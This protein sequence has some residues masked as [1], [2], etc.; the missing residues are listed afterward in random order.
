MTG[1]HAHAHRVPVLTVE[2]YAGVGHPHGVHGDAGVVPVVSFRNVEENEHGL[3]AL[4]LDLDAVES[5]E[6][7]EGKQKIVH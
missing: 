6:D 2:N 4:I 1:L 7:P 3:F 5:A